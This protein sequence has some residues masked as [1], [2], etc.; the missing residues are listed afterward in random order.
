MPIFSNLLGSFL[1][2]KH[3]VHTSDVRDTVTIPSS[4]STFGSLGFFGGGGKLGGSSEKA[5]ENA[6]LISSSALSAST[7]SVPVSSN[8]S[9]SVSSSSLSSSS[10]SSKDAVNNSDPWGISSSSSSVASTTPIQYESYSREF[11]SITMQDNFDGFR[12]EAAKNVNKYLQ[13]CHTLFLGTR[14]RDEGYIYQFGPT[15][16]LD[17]GSL[18]LMA[19]Y[20]LDQTVNA[21]FLKKLSKNFEFRLNANSSLTEEQRNM[22][23][24]SFDNTGS[25]W[26]SSLKFAWQGT[27]IV[28]GSFSQMIHPKLHLGGELTWIGANGASI[29][30]IG[31]RYT[32]GKNII[33]CQ[34]S[35]Q[36]D[37]K[38]PT[39][40]T[41]ET[42]SGKVQYV[43]KITDR[44]S[45]ATELEY[46]HPDMESSMKI[47]WEYAFRHA[48][49][50]GLID[51]CG[52]VSLSAQDASG[53]GVS[54]VIDYWKNDY[55]FGFMMHVVPPPEGQNPAL[56]APL[57]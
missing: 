31:A 19:R 54:G 38:S 57:Y 51:T 53:F 1:P 25:D 28:N 56:N 42:H 55:K 48:R 9:N 39:G 47:G 41:K 2:R 23:E 22:Y 24:L 17:D 33:S 50:Q 26:A 36:P 40:L 15:F 32:Q 21:R 5:T 11:Q 10:S 35:R 44:L 3:V 6:S 27:W 14:L 8:A 18:L 16:A 43:R 7:A 12:L 45:A 37:F 49:I 4:S 20:S 30:A 29:G 34:L 52:R 46:T 13:T